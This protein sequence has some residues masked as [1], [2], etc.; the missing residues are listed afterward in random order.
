VTRAAIVLGLISAAT[1]PQPNQPQYSRVVQLLCQLVLR[2][3]DASPALPTSSS[4]ELDQAIVGLLDVCFHTAEA[5]TATATTNRTTLQPLFSLTRVQSAQVTL[6]LISRLLLHHEQQQE[7]VA[8]LCTLILQ[9]LLLLHRDDTEYVHSVL[10]TLLNHIVGRGEVAPPSSSPPPPPS[11]P[12]VF[13]L[14]ALFDTMT[15]LAATKSLSAATYNTVISTLTTAL[16][17]SSNMTTRL[18]IL[19]ALRTF[20]QNALVS[21]VP[22]ATSSSSSPSS[23]SSSPNSTFLKEE[24]PYLRR[25]VATALL[26]ALLPDIVVLFHNYCSTVLSSE[27]SVELSAPNLPPSPSSPPPPPPPPKREELWCIEALKNI[28]LI[29][30]FVSPTTTTHSVVLSLVLPVLLVVLKSCHHHH[31]SSNFSTTTATTTTT[32]ISSE[33]IATTPSSREMLRLISVQVLLRLAQTTDATLLQAFKNSI[34]QLSTADRRILEEVLRT[35]LLKQQQS[36]TSH[37]SLT[38][39]SLQHKTELTIDVSKYE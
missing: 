19:E 24:W 1:S 6:W 12:S 4:L 27:E 15:V 23:S 10:H 20:A 3:I 14:S 35:E 13:A 5:T 38:T 33:T 32:T 30:S 26:R 2:F 34:A 16:R 18:H 22:P 29:H 36:T 11:P 7:R 8:S 28:L 39:P 21:D 31:H 9:D 37:H 25:C 17:N